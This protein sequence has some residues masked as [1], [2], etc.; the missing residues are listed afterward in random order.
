MTAV[1]EKTEI[2]TADVAKAAREFARQNGIEVGTR[3]RLSVEHFTQYFLAQP[4]TARE[5]AAHI[6]VPVSRRG[7][8]SEQDATK[9]ALHFR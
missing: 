8:L 7:R 6:G 5:L 4:R 2:Y 3:G 9:V 1:A